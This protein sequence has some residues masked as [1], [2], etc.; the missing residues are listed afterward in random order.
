MKS[1]TWHSFDLRSGRRGPQ[2]VPQAAGEF[3]RIVSEATEATVAVSCW[4]AELQQPR[5]GW[6]AGTLPGRVMLVALDELHAP[7]WG[8]M[9]L[10]RVSNASSWVTCTAVTLEH[11]LDRRYVGDL[12]FTG[13]DASSD[14]AVIAA[15]VID[16][17][18]VDGLNFVVDAPVTGVLLAR[19][20]ADNE[21]KTVLSALT[22]LAAADTPLEYTVDLAWT[23]DTKTVLQRTL[24]IRPRIGTSRPEPV[25]FSMPGP[26]KN[27]DFTEDY[28]P[29]FGA[30]DV[31]A[32]S[33]GE[34]DARPTSSHHVATDLLANGWAR[35]ENR[36]TPATSVTDEAQLDAAAAAELTDMQAGIQQLQLE[37]NLDTA[38]QVNRDFWLGDDI[39]A[40]LTCPRF[41]SYVDGDGLLQPG[42]VRTARCVGWSV[43]IAARTLKPM[44]REIDA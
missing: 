41:P 9:V 13:E 18:T 30:N 7:V 39:T 3:G 31:M 29:E 44:L 27:F 36:F 12:E 1:V 34:G 26:V 5:T 21:D 43:D 38:P 28:S 6:D 15:G 10:R 35:F 11:Y 22:E 25:V 42:F 2:L 8:G 24:R 14:Q 20:Y 19:T 40:V 16:A 37:A 33:S 32:T 4:D 17:M 23:D